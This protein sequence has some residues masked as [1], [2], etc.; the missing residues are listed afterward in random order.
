MSI[1]KDID[2]WL[3]WHRTAGKEP[4]LRVPVFASANTI[5]KFA[6]KKRGGP[7]MYRKHV[8]VPLHPTR[9]LDEIRHERNLNR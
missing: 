8:I 1:R 6:R 7:Y 3:N 9:T 4:P 2:H 5:R